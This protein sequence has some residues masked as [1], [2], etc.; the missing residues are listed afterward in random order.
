MYCCTYLVW[1][2]LIAHYPA[3]RLSS[4]TF[5]TPLFGVMAGVILLSE[6]ASAALIASLLLVGI[7]IYLVNRRDV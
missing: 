6:A 3:S 7:G 5:L 1:F 2:W 4:Y